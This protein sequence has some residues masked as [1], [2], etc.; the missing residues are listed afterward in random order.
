V[1][2]E[3]W[4]LGQQSEIDPASPQV[5]N[6]QNDVVKLYTGD[7]AKQWDAMLNDIDVEPLTNLQQA[8]Q[9]LYVL[10]SP[11]SPM[12]DLLVSMTRQLTL[13]QAPPPAPGAA[14]AAAGLVQSATAATA[15]AANSA[16]AGI[17]AGL[18]GTTN[19]P[20]PEPPGKVIETRY[21]KLIS[22][23]GKGPGAP[24]D[25][26]LKLLNDVQQQLAQIANAG[27]GSA[28]TPAAGGDPAQLLQAEAAGDPQPVQRWLAALAISGNSQRS[29]GAKKAAAQAFNAPGGPASLCKQAVAGRYPFTQGSPS[30]IPLD[31]FGRLFSANGMINQFFNQQLRPFVDTSGTPWKAQPVAGVAPPI[32]P[33][34]LAQFQRAAAIGDLFFAGGAA[35]PTVRFEITP[36]TLDGGAKQVTL[37]LGGQVITYAHGPQRSTPI[38]WPGANGINSARLVFE[39]APSSG[40]PVLSASGPWALFRLFD[41]GT[42]QQSGSSERYTLTFHVGDRQA[43]FE[44]RAGSVLNPF[45]PGILHDFRCPGL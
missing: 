33:G 14:G 3:S 1:A 7:Y 44:I 24:I 32:S 4:V 9:D 20:P 36:G 45:A 42:L 39:P 43:S 31:D 2:S 17:S 19:G 35:Q 11:Q 29:G 40:P 37:E 41:Q 38:A 8:V 25:T 12:R 15:N 30:D 23:V 10:S 27:P 34:D 13:T 5:L 26:A 21:A 16:A 22:F 6:L 28:A 18:F